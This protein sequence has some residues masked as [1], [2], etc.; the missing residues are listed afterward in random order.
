MRRELPEEGCPYARGERGER[1]PRGEQGIRGPRGERGPAGE[2]GA[3]GPRGPMGPQGNTAPLAYADFYAMMPADNRAA[4][5]P[6]GEIA[7]PREG[8]CHGGITRTESGILLDAAG[9][10]AVFF[11]LAA[12]GAG[13][14]ILALDGGEL[15]YTT[16]G[17]NLGGSELSGNV[18]IRTEHPQALLSLHNPQSAQTPLLLTPSAG[19]RAPVSAHLVILR[20]S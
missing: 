9:S 15:P 7:F 10:Y 3:I 19:G 13:Q 16:V 6:G 20:L 4:I 18:L 14:V 8:V 17:C 1:G 2:R 5:P 11:S 12:S